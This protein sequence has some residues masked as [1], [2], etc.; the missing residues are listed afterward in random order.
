MRLATL[1]AA[2]E[3]TWKSVVVERDQNRE[4]PKEL[5][6]YVGFCRGF[7][8][9]AVEAPEGARTM[10]EAAYETVDT[11]SGEFTTIPPKEVLQRMLDGW[12][13][14]V[15]DVRIK[16][17]EKIA[18]L[19]FT[20][21]LIPHREVESTDLPLNRD[22]LFFCKGGVRSNKVCKRAVREFGLD[23][24]IYE[25]E[26]GIMGWKKEIDDSIPKY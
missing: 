13:P 11:S 14:Y 24:A 18:R 19:P 7:D 26:G 17:E 12:N 2:L 6:D 10:D 16:P 8:A 25:I 9:P 15:I 1:V 21:A 4:V 22:V 3:G 5:V 23:N 20:D